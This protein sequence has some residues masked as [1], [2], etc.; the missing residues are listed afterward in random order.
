[1]S[2][3]PELLLLLSSITLLY[4]KLPTYQVPRSATND[5][6]LVNRVIAHLVQNAWMGTFF[7]IWMS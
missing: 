6:Q 5:L 7:W 3:I 2:I 1:M 4:C